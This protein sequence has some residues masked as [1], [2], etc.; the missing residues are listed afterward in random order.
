MG[1]LLRKS[2]VH[3][4]FRTR[5]EQKQR[6]QAKRKNENLRNWRIPNLEYDIFLYAATVANLPRYTAKN[7]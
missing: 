4:D 7:R 2:H 1:Y 5:S 3:R 6:V